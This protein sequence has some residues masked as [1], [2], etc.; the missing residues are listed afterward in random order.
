[1]TKFVVGRGSKKTIYDLSMIPGFKVGDKSW[2]MAIIKNHPEYTDNNL[3]QTLILTKQEAN[4][5]R[6]VRG[7][8]KEAGEKAHPG[9]GLYMMLCVLTGAKLR[10]PIL[11]GRDE[12]IYPG[13]TS[14]K[15]L[16]TMQAKWKDD[17]RK[18]R[19][20]IG[21]FKPAGRAKGRDGKGK[22]AQG[23]KGGGG[24]DEGT[25][26]SGAGGGAMKGLNRQPITQEAQ[27]RNSSNPY[28]I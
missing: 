20:H 12:D 16:K 3:Q 21:I 17:T 14:W 23:R 9:G 22:G 26:V 5:L 8:E 4:M 1:M 2:M 19:E 13:F 24:A 10:T 18:Q 27:F 25:P 11:S 15:Y 6:G 7:K 28:A